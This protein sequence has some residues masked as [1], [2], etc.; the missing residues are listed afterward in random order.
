MLLVLVFGAVFF[1]ILVG[2]SGFVLAQNRTQEVV[3]AQSE[4]SSIAEA[5]LEYYRWL[6]SHYPGDTQNHTGHNG[7]FVINYTNGEGQNAGTYT[8][9][10]VGNEACGAVQSIDV[11]SK[12]V[13]A[14][15]PNESATL[16]ARY[17]QPSVARY[18][19]ILNSSVWFGPGP[20]FGPV[21]SNGGIRMDGDPNAPVTSS[22]T[23]WTCDP[24]YGCSGHQTE[25]GVFGSGSNPSMWSYPTPQTDFG[26]IASDYA[27]L[28]SI[29]Q[30]MGLYFPRI[31]TSK[32]PYL[33]YH[34]VFNG[35][36]TVTVYQVTSVSK[37]L[38]SYPADG[39]Y[40]Y[41]KQDYGAIT[42]ET[43]L[44]TYT[45]P[46]NCGL[47]FVED[48]VWMEGSISG[49]VTVVAANV[50]NPGVYPNIQLTNNIT[51]TSFDGTAGL[52]AIASH[53]VLINPVAP[54]DLTLDGIFVA[55]S[56]AFGVNLYPCSTY[57]NKSTLNMLG[58]V[59]SSMR[60]TTYWMY[61]NM[62]NGCSGGSSGYPNG[63]SAFDRQN[64]T[65]PPPFTPITSTQWQFV[66][67]KQE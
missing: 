37:N 45:V 55:Q 63:T 14:D 54:A 16:W 66:D 31:S 24:S 2:L 43:L 58:T 41:S 3:R 17:A 8:L 27:S 23:T 57:G 18:N 56:G 49:K 59:V 10:V 38:R 9:S 44:G 50:T 61:G 35:D 32:Q 47:I 46:T 42:A 29:A 5:G 39:V 25:P 67:W 20:I 12:G 1:A 34:L 13:P 48:N 11:T 30:S 7:P 52:T 36:G 19:M 15:A 62:G 21:H 33:G 53:S 26:A 28:K 6:L 22:V 65:N 4:A 51:Y 40:G 64:S 60:P